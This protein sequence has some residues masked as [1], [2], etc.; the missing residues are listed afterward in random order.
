HVDIKHY[1][2]GRWQ[3]EFVLSQLAGWFGGLRCGGGG[4]LQFCEQNSGKD[5]RCADSS[6]S[7]EPL[8]NQQVRSERGEDG[9]QREE[10]RGVTRGCE[11]LRPKLN[12][13][14][15]GGCKDGAD[16]DARIQLPAIYEAG[17]LQSE[18]VG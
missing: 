14:G 8:V 3:F 17:A 10:D 9:L 4:P 15:D 16:G 6:A 7:A 1:S 2:N 12:G 11:A 13:E 5:K 18:G